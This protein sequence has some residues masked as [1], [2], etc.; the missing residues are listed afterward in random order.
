LPPSGDELQRYWLERLPEGE[1][2]ILEILLQEA[3]GVDREA[4]TDATGYKRSTRD[5]YLARMTAKRI[6]QPIGRG[7]VKAVEE[8]FA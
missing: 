1:K 8:F 2:K 5:A 6:V 7:Q 4:L 3:N